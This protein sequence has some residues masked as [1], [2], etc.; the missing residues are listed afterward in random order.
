MKVFL[1]LAFFIVSANCFSQ[2]AYIKGQVK[3]ATEKGEVKNASLHFLKND[4]TI[5]TG[6]HG[7][8]KIELTKYLSDSVIISHWSLGTIRYFFN[9]KDKSSV[10]KD[11]HFSIA[12]RDVKKTDVCPM[13]K[14][15]KQVIQIVY[16]FPTQETIKRAEK[17][18]LWLGG[19]MIEPCMPYYYCKKD[20]F[21]F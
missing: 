11:F 14:S 8:Y 1:A 13:C 19:C 20:G 9:L 15:N 2:V 5:L 17:G 4:T 10:T 21:E 7:S 12:C 16:G 18:E 6:T 3:D